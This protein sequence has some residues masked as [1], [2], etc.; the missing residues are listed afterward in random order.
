[1]NDREPLNYLA[2]D[3]LDEIELL[4][5]V[6]IVASDAGSSLSQPLIDEVLGVD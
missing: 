6:I 4:S 1:M 2:S 5:E 3:E